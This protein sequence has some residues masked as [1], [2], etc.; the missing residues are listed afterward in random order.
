M[1]SAS[2]PVGKPE[3]ARAAAIALCHGRDDEGQTV[4]LVIN[5]L[6]GR[7]DSPA[8]GERR[9]TRGKKRDAPQRR[10]EKHA[11][12]VRDDETLGN[13]ISE[14]LASGC[15][16]PPVTSQESRGRYS[17]EQKPKG[18]KKQNTRARVRQARA[19][20]RGAVFDASKGDGRMG[21]S[22][23]A[24][25]RRAR[26]A[27]SRECRGPGWFLTRPRNKCGGFE[28]ELS[29]SG[30]GARFV[31]RGFYPR[32]RA[33]GAWPRAPRPMVLAFQSGGRV[34]GRSG[35]RR[36]SRFR[37]GS[38]GP[39]VSVVEAA[40]YNKGRTR[41]SALSAGVFSREHDGPTSSCSSMTPSTDDSTAII[42]SA[43]KAPLHPTP[44]V[45]IEHHRQPRQLR[46]TQRRGMRRPP[47]KVIR[48]LMD[49]DKKT[50]FFRTNRRLVERALRRATPDG[51]L[52][53]VV[54]QLNIESGGTRAHRRGHLADYEA[55]PQAS[56]SADKMGPA[57]SRNP[58][59]FLNCIT[60]NFSISAGEAARKDTRSFDEAFL[61]TALH[62]S[63]RLRVGKTI[64][65]G[66]PLVTSGG[67]G[68]VRFTPFAL[69][70][71]K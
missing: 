35:S 46:L 26:N 22:Q 9:C 24:P 36:E 27:E 57:G 15:P 14:G 43:A 65:M 39:R 62:A 1:G 44:L 49:A 40:V 38:I 32:R 28:T 56:C 59:S 31:R 55:N 21:R 6:L 64:D 25:A 10:A 17:A 18:G 12:N 11:L 19:E 33:P 30:A 45:M 13:R 70:V 8:S 71:H 60:R 48:R 2:L 34:K 67:R 50:L 41:S 51:M 52:Q 37:A 69:G 53:A 5:S 42:A 61:V 63:G 4:R 7:L 47:A 23:R 16:S 3:V 54:G 20:V 66:Y 58:T 68:G 29:G